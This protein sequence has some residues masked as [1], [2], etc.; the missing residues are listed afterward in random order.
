MQQAE[1][2]IEEEATKAEVM[3][4]LETD[5]TFNR[6]QSTELAAKTSELEADALLAAFKAKMGGDG[7][8]LGAK[9]APTRA[10]P[11]RAAA[12]TAPA[13]P[14]GAAAK[15]PPAPSKSSSGAATAPKSEPAPPAGETTPSDAESTGE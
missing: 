6:L 8:Q 14:S 4:M 1:D 15:S 7:K 9:S 13:K 3:G 5:D 10:L 2:R 11:D 12:G